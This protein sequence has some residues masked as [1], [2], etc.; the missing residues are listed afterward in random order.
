M[1][2]QLISILSSSDPFQQIHL[3]ISQYNILIIKFIS[4]GFPPIFIFCFLNQLF[5]LIVLF[6]FHDLV[7]FNIIALYFHIIIPLPRNHSSSV[8]DNFIITINRTTII[9]FFISFVIFTFICLHFG[10]IVLFYVLY[11]HWYLSVYNY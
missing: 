3:L 2:I 9:C 1:I 7:A 6:L 5:Q 8:Q 11:F 4:N 10:L